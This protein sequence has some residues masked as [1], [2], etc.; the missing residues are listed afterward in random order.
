VL[1]RLIVR[2]LVAGTIL[3]TGAVIIEFFLEA[4]DAAQYTT[5][6]TFAEVGNA[7]VRYKLLG[8]EHPGA[9]VVFLSGLLGTIEQADQLQSAVAR[10]VPALAYDRAGYGFSEGSTA[11]DG[12]DQAAELAGLL[13]ALKIKGPVVLVPYSNS[14]DLAR[15]FAGRYPEKTAGIYMLEPSMPDINELVPAAH[16]PRRRFVRFIGYNLVG[17]SLGYLRLT[18]RLKDWQGPTS[19]VEQR[20]E[21]ILVGRRHYW[22]LAKEWYAFPDTSKQVLEAPVPPALPIELAV[23]KRLT[24]DDTTKAYD[25]L[26]SRFVARSSRG[27][28]VELEHVGHD[29][30]QVPGPAFNHIVAD[31]Q[32]LS[33]GRAP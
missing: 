5:G 25:K 23:P 7:R 17:S 29:K 28:I 9:T 8:T 33:L 26:Y 3:V 31:I 11:H 19:P 2:F 21:A 12:W 22:A 16:T 4:R 18:H 14:A 10:E 1:R 27:K 13:D 32:Q 24:E 30:L 15:V 6:Q 20:A